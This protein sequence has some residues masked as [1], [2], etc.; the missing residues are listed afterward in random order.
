MLV[1]LIKPDV[2]YNITPII[3]SMTWDTDF[4]LLSSM[5]FELVYS[6]A[7]YPTPRNPV[8]PGDHIIVTRHGNEVFR[9]V[10]AD[11]MMTGRSPIKYIAYDYTWYLAQSTTVVQFNRIPASVAIER[12]LTEFGI[13]IGNIPYMPTIID[14]IYIEKSPAHILNDIITTVENAEGYRINGEMR[15]GRI[16]LERHTDRIIQGRFRL[17]D[18]LPEQDV[19]TAVSEPKRTR[20]IADMRN[21]IRL[22]IDDE[23]EDEQGETQASYIETALVQ[24]DELI[25]R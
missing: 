23:V 9:G 4:T 17:A 16:Y 25:D 10:I 12:V 21:R 5:E 20:S 22:I 11:E 1:T 14:Q 24:D 15:E 3:G 6:D 19:L 7:H 8:D 13:Q 2:R 18:N